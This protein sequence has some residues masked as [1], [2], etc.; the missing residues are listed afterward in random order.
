MVKTVDKLSLKSKIEGGINNPQ[1][2]K[3][4]KVV[5]I[6]FFFGKKSNLP[7]DCFVFDRSQNSNLYDSSIYLAGFILAFKLMV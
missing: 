7:N 5:Q 6:S 1:F 3:K 4:S 2:I